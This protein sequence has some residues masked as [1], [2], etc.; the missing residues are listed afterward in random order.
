MNG[1]QELLTRF[2][3]DERER[4]GYPVEPCH[5]A[6]VLLHRALEAWARSKQP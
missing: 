1:D 2:V 6:R 4:T 5:A 3:A